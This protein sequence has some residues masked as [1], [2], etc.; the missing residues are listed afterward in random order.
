MIEGGKDIL[1]DAQVQEVAKKTIEEAERRRQEAESAGL[2]DLG[3][4]DPGFLDVAGD[5][6]VGALEIAVEIITL[7]LSLL[8]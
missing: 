4:V 5:I 3:F 6:A 2:G 1:G 7:P 8:E